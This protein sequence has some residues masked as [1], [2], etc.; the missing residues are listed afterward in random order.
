M[1]LVAYEY[2]MNIKCCGFNRPSNVLVSSNEVNSIKQNNKHEVSYRIT[3]TNIPFDSY[4]DVYSFL[5]LRRLSSRWCLRVVLML[6]L[7]GFDWIMIID[8]ANFRWLLMTEY[9]KISQRIS[10]Y[11]KYITYNNSWAWACWPD[12]SLFYLLIEFLACLS[13]K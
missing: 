9:E 8:V 13:G 11:Q 12:M 5:L 4:F 6:S 7:L 10:W 2:P 1:K 3:I